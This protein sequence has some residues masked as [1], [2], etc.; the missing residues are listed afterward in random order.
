MKPVRAELRIDCRCRLGEGVLWN[1]DEARLY[2]VD[3]EAGRLYRWDLAGDPEHFDLAAK[4]GGFVFGDDGSILLFGED[5]L[6]RRWDGGEPTVVAQAPGEV[7]GRFNDVSATPSG[8]VLCGTM[9]IGDR[10][11]TLYLL[12]LG[13]NLTPILPDVGCSNG[14]GFSPDRKWVYF[15]DTRR[16]T[17]YRSP[18]EAPFLPATFRPEP[19]IV[20]PEGRGGPDGLCVDAE[21]GI[22]SARWGGNGVVRYTPDGE[23]DFWV[24]LP[25][26]QATSCAFGGPDLRT[27]FITSAGYDGP[28]I[29]GGLFSAEVPFAGQPEPTARVRT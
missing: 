17:I 4:L 29:A 2:W 10:P 27:L 14:I 24:E 8:E 21:G 12:D 1:S 23:E 22:W 15:T 16:R 19:F 6:I 7:G 3:I 25:V 20:V 5:G 26:P 9:P 11:G 18:L 13:G 28:E